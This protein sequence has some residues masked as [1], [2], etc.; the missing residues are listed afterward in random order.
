[1]FNVRVYCFIVRNNE[2]MLLKEPFAGKLVVK[3]PGGGL[4]E[5][6][7]TIDCL[8]RELKEELN[9]NLTS[10]TH[11]YTLGQYADSPQ[12]KGQFLPIYYKVEVDN[13]DEIKILDQKIEEIIWKNISELKPEDLDLP[14]D[15]MVVRKFF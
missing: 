8:K 6:E 9:L 2:L 5:G 15:Q 10:A 7:G 1:M 13:W 4:E 3:L 11:L 12:T 14:I